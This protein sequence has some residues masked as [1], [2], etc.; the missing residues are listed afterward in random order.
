MPALNER[1]MVLAPWCEDKS[2]EEEIKN[3]TAELSKQQVHSDEATEEG[4][5]TALTGW[6]GV[7]NLIQKLVKF[8]NF[9]NNF[10]AFQLLNC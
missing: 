2:T 1:K 7:Q 3:Q 6:G 8:Q 10:F 5:Q 4:F 9:K